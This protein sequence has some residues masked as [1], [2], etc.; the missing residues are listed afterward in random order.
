MSYARMMVSV[1]LGP[2]AAARVRLAADLA[3]RL[4]AGLTGIAATRGPARPRGAATAGTALRLHDIERA[5]L[6]FEGNAGQVARTAWR[7]RAANAAV[8]LVDQARSADLVVLGRAGDLA[9]DLAVEPGRVLCGAGRPV[10]L[11]PPGFERLAAARVVVAFG[12]GPQARRAVT[13]AMPLLQRADRVFVAARDRERDAG[14]AEEVAAYLAGHG[15][16]ATTDLLRGPA[17][18]PD[19]LLDLIAGR[20][21]DLVVLGA[22]GPAWLPGRPFDRLTRAMLRN[23]PICCLMSR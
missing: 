7:A 14:A 18:D 23:A 5:R 13:G 22:T 15:A 9:A 1:D 20:R 10:L 2:A 4:G 21:A 19:A 11:A 12:D 3:H 16:A 17:G 8:F 6:L